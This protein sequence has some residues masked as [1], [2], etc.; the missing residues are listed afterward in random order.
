MSDRIRIAGDFG[1]ACNNALLKSFVELGD[2]HFKWEVNDKPRK[3]NEV[4]RTVR[5]FLLKIPR[6]EVDVMDQYIHELKQ[7]LRVCFSVMLDLFFW[8]GPRG[9]RRL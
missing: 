7:E 3:I 1:Q 9:I 4:A 6:S 8:S 2:K 5:P